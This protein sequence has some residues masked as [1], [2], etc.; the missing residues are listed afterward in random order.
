M[1]LQ[2][3]AGRRQ[4][5]GGT[6][7][8]QSAQGAE[9]HRQRGACPRLPVR[10]GETVR[11]ACAH[12]GS[13]SKPACNRAAAS[14]SQRCQA[15]AAEQ[16]CACELPRFN[17]TILDACLPVRRL[18]C[19]Q[20]VEQRRPPLVHHLAAAPCGRL[21]RLWFSE[22][23]TVQKE[24]GCAQGGCRGVRRC[25]ISPQ[26]QLGSSGACAR[27]WAAADGKHEG[28][29]R[30]RRQD[31]RGRGAVLQRAVGGLLTT[32]LSTNRLPPA[33]TC[34]FLAAAAASAAACCSSS[35]SS[36]KGSAS[37]SAAAVSAGPAAAGC[38]AAPEA[39]ASRAS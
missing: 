31:S 18:S 30:K 19:V 25:T 38:C 23:Q 26:L 35:A 5:A 7:P 33:H 32:W 20:A 12:L 17:P 37:T 9:R 27:R 6:L 14:S 39:S 21:G 8:Q 22:G 36:P 2:S 15:T 4:P 16:G 24:E 28:V 11:V 29:S 34:R 1:C 13:T 10:G 3:Q